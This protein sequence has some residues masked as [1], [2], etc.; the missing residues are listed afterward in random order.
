MTKMNSRLVLACATLAAAS[1]FIGAGCNSGGGDIDKP[2][3]KGTDTL[4][5]APNQGPAPGM[6]DPKG[7]PAASPGTMTLPPGKSG[8]K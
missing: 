5:Q 4:P 3:V 7:G 6:I 2:I 1:C 8:G